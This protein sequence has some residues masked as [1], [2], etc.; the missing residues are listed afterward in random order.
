[1]TG[2][3]VQPTAD[4]ELLATIHAETVAFAY[5]GFFPEGSM[6]PTTEQ[7]TRFWGKYLASPAATALVAWEGSR[8]LGA[9]AVRA[10]PNFVGEGQLSGLHV[11]PPEWG[12]GVGGSLH[13]S[14]LNVLGSR[15]FRHAGLWVIQ[16]N[17]RA[18]AMYESRGWPRAGRR[19][20]LRRRYRGALQQEPG[21]PQLTA[22]YHA[23]GQILSALD[24]RVSRARR[25]SFDAPRRRRS[26]V[27]E[28]FRPDGLV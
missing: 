25:R 9:V 26:P 2:L 27:R 19:T 18:R 10:D 17:V 15:S 4:A 8:A 21:S 5:A 12:R 28:K 16:A 14:A 7:L 23:E 24:G 6:P 11:R 22:N 13:D 20:G 1:M 3:R